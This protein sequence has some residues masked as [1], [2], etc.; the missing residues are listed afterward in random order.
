MS[1]CPTL[2]V[3]SRQLRHTWPSTPPARRPSGPRDP[4][5]SD[6][7]T[8]ATTDVPDILGP[9]IGPRTDP[10]SRA[11]A[12]PRNYRCTGHTWPRQ[13]ARPPDRGR[14]SITM[15]RTYLASETAFSGRSTLAILETY[16]ARVHHDRPSILGACTHD[17]PD[18]LLPMNRTYLARALTMN[19]TYHYR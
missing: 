11:R 8:R 16:D 6:P 2:T 5:Q 10:K 3:C 1:R 9:G 4:T 7:R 18:I 15:N 13:P 17:V 14:M 12:P 19:R